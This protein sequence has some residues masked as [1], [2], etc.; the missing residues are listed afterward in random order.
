MTRVLAVAALLA[1][2]LA[3]LPAQDQAAFEQGYGRIR[4]LLQKEKWNDAK[5]AIDALLAANQ[6]QLWAV[7]ER[8]T[9][10]EDCRRCAFAL[11]VKAPK[12]QE[13]IAGEILSWAPSNGRIKL[14]YTPKTMRDWQKEAGQ[15]AIYLHP[16][17]FKG[18]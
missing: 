1:A 17:A 9:I 6:G 5:T 18:E 13:L 15:P 16:A 3:P 10:V 7:A 8:E 4:E 11:E 12:P 2:L 14:R